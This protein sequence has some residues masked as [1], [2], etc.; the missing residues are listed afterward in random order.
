MPKVVLKVNNPLISVLIPLYNKEKEVLRAVNSVLSQTIQ[1][2]EIIVVNDGS[3]DEG[4][5]IVRDIKDSRIRVI[6]QDNAGVSAARNRGIT[7]A[8]A[9]LIA[10]LD[11]DDEWG[12][13]FLETVVNLKNTYTSCK[14]Y[15][16]NYY[17]RRSNNYNRPTI[18]RGL[19]NK[20]REG[21][22]NDYFQIASRSDPPLCASAVAVSKKAIN[23][24]GG[25]PLGIDRGEDLL[26]WARLATK[27]QIAYSILPKAIFW[28]PVNVAARSE[29]VTNQSDIVG[30]ELEKLLED[31]PDY[32][33]VKLKNYISHW[34]KMRASIYLQ[35][36]QKVLAIKEIMTA[37]RF[38]GVSLRLFVYL[39]LC[40]LPKKSY[41]K[42]KEI[43][44]LS[45]FR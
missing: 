8:K 30:K 45:N 9:E 40:L 15:A 20:F 6:D 12:N 18:I 13:D 17:F 34:H 42:L 10:F 38:G 2:F 33:K 37:L 1:D 22:L 35:M 41:I 27:F 14:V 11:A 43:Y 3:T 21:I 36:G 7:E 44:Q 5:E 19:P 32:S 28:E 23:D 39:A 29:R 4:P 25:F 26:T 31:I 24:I 16:T